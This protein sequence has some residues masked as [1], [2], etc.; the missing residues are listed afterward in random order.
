MAEDLSSP[1]AT[2]IYSVSFR[3][4]KLFGIVPFLRTPEFILAKV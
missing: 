1:Q 2:T 3:G 4:K